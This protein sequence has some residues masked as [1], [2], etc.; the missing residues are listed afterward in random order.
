MKNDHLNP[1][2]ILGFDA[3]TGDRRVA[4]LEHLCGCSTCR[5]ACLASDEAGVFALLSR[6]AIP[7]EKLDQLSLRID[8]AL[9]DVR[10]AVP[11]R[12]NPFHRVA[13][14]AASV[15]LAAVLG[16]VMWN[17]EAPEPVVSFADIEALGVEEAISGIRL[18]STPGDRPQVLD[19]SI[20]GTQILMIFD[21]S[22]EL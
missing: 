8:A 14:I 11:I 7:Q 18:V 21:E 6:V 13:S 1:E 15:L 19:L 20:G 16:A 5:E 4:A 12:R 2:E 17:H 22:I 3:L 9:D 10:P